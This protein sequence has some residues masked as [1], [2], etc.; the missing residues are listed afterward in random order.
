MYSKE[1]YIEIYFKYI[2][3]LCKKYKQIPMPFE[4]L[5]IKDVV[6]E[7]NQKIYGL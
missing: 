1:K 5:K 4:K 2:D 7:K 3:Y 6:H